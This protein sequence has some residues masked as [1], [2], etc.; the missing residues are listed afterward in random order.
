MKAHRRHMH[1]RPR[2]MGA[3]AAAMAGLSVQAQVVI[4][5][6]DYD[7]LGTDAA[8]YIEILNVGTSAFPLQYLQVVMVNGNAGGAVVYRT[9]ESASWPAL[10]PGEYFVICASAAVP[11]C[12]AVV[13]PATNLIQ[14]GSPDAIALVTTQPVPMV[15]DALSYGG[16]VPGYTE[17]TGT[18]VEDS[19]LVGGISI[20]RYPDGA[21]SGDNAADFALMCSTPGAVNLVDP[22]AC[23]LSTGLP[24]RVA[25]SAAFTAVPVVGASGF[26]V[27]AENPAGAALG[28]EVF[29]AQGAL[30]ATYGPSRAVKASW[31]VD[32]PGTPGQVL[33]VR[34]TGGDARKALRIVAP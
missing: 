4:N 8:E 11:E 22:D 15:I 14:N 29:D 12:D 33:L 32:I 9:L 34:L 19:N 17:G 20:G 3:M 30:L 31:H 21:D 6:V 16:S 23:D 13:S 25:A 10:G 1:R 5:E 7:Q 26:V 28:I 24:E 27:F 18:P 2:S